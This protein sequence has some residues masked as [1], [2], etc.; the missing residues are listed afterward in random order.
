MD[1]TS[2][3]FNHLIARLPLE[4][5]ERLERHLEPVRLERRDVIYDGQRP[6]EHVL[7]PTT[8]VASLIQTMEDGST[9]EA[10]TVGNE[11][12]TGVLLA[13][14]SVQ[15]LGRVIIQLSGEALRTEASR[16]QRLCAE[17][18]AAQHVMQ[19]FLHAFLMQLV[20]STA[21]NQFH[22]S[23]QRCARWLVTMRDRTVSDEM[24]LTHEFLAEMLGVRRATV[25]H[26]VDRLQSIG[27]IE[28]RHG[29]I[30]ITDRERL[31]GASC[32]CY[33]AVRTKSQTVY[34]APVDGARR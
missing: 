1:R 3:P 4:A 8:C 10:A 29:R 20:Q 33:R 32:E 28:A 12:T 17:I 15:P 9:A 24:A 34:D 27:A 19:R 13:I 11:G 7:F 30:I 14:G 22:S 31:E 16:L 26:I 23:M 2:K 5:R 25:T 18:P 6:I 21:C